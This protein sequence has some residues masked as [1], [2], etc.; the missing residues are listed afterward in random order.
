M[1]R[2]IR[3]L[4]NR[5]ICPSFRE[6]ARASGIKSTG[7]LSQHIEVLLERRLIDLMPSHDRTILLTTAGLRA[8]GIVTL[9]DFGPDPIV[10]LYS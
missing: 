5:G 10:R 9:A 1:L 6:I 3:G 4:H 7:H 2:A 8:A